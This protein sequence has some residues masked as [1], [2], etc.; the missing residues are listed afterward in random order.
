MTNDNDSENDRIDRLEEQV[1]QLRK[2]QERRNE[3]FVDMLQRLP[4]SRRRVLQAAA[5]AGLLGTGAVGGALGAPGD[6]GDTVWGSSSNR[7]DYY[8]DEIDA[9]LVNTGIVQ[10]R[11]GA[12]V[13]EDDNSPFN[14]SGSQSHTLSLSSDYESIRA[15]VDVENTSG[16][17]QDLE[18]RVNGNSSSE[19]RYEDSAA[20]QTSGDTA[21]PIDNYGGGGRTIS[22]EI[23]VKGNWT[24]AE[25]VTFR[26]LTCFRGG[27]SP[28]AVS[29]SHDTVTA[30]INSITLRGTA[31]TIDINKV[32]VIGIQT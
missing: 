18:L 2:Q 22:G 1:E 16:G 31:G 12:I 27:T 9:N 10:F 11:E 7:D 23:I 26:N 28:I 3:A 8:A 19:Y 32:R 30:P 29:G 13:Q 24:G 15:I 5:A 14:P 17:N 20:A 6:D 21:W 25:N 4:V